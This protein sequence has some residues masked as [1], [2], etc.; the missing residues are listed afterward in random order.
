[1]EQISEARSGC[2]G[3]T[4]FVF[5][6]PASAQGGGGRSAIAITGRLALLSRTARRLE[7]FAGRVNRG[8]APKHAQRREQPHMRITG[9]VVLG[10]SPSASSSGRLNRRRALAVVARA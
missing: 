9:V 6:L 10:Q 3:T 8:A 7:F 2:A 1:M 5:V 4:V